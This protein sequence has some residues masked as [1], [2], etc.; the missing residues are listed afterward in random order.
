MQFISLL[1]DH[2]A[3]KSKQPIKRPRGTP[4]GL[5]PKQP[6]KKSTATD[7]SPRRSS[8]RQLT[9]SALPPQEEA[10]LS[11]RAYIPWTLEESEALLDYLTNATPAG[12]HWYK[13]RNPDFWDNASTYI[14]QQLQDNRRS[15][16]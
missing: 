10:S 3:S 5:T 2:M 12:T 15:G 7:F 14:H 8:R 9:Y 16:I 1:S 11:T 4:T 6:E 13:G